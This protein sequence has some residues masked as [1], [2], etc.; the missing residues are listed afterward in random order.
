MDCPI[1]LEP[2]LPSNQTGWP[3]LL[4][5]R[6][7]ALNIPNTQLSL[8]SD[9]INTLREEQ[10]GLAKIYDDIPFP[11]NVTDTDSVEFV[12]WVHAPASNVLMGIGKCFVDRKVVDAGAF[13]L[14]VNDVL[15]ADVPIRAGKIKGMLLNQPN[16]LFASRMS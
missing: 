6:Y 8:G 12:T 16:P 14:Y 4:I 5:A 3:T 11:D 15:A 9:F 10:P 1:R 7:A 2:V 13:I